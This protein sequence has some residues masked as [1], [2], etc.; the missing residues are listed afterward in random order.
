MQ[1]ITCC[2]IIPYNGKFLRGEFL[3]D[4]DLQIF[5]GKYFDRWSLVFY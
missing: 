3:M 5:E 1:R 4:I 2:Y